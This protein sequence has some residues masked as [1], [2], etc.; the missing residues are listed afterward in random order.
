MVKNKKISFLVVVLLLLMASITIVS[1]ND[2]NTQNQYENYISNV[3][4]NQ[5]E[6]GNS[7]EYQ[8][9]NHK[10]DTLT[11]NSKNESKAGSNSISSNQMTLN[12]SVEN[13]TVTLVYDT[14]KEVAITKNISTV[15]GKPDVTKLGSDYAYA[16]ENGVYTILG[17]EIRRVMKLDSYCQQIY[18]FVPK[19]TFFRKEGSNVKY[20]IS[21][22]KWNVIARSLNAYHVKKGYESVPTPYSI[23]VNL[24]DQKYFYSVYYDA[25]EWIN[26]QQYTCGPTAMS[27]ISQALNCF[28]SERK[29]VG[30]YSTTVA[31]GTSESKIIKYSPLVHMK[32]TDIKDDK[33]SVKNALLNGKMIFWHIS[34][35]Y[36]CI[37]GYN[38]DKDKFLCLNPSGPSHNINAVQWATWSQITNTDRSLKEHG[39]MQ[40]QPN[41]NLTTLDKTHVKYYYYNMGGKYAI[42]NNLEYPNNNILKYSV[43]ASSSNVITIT[44]QTILHIKTEV[45][46]NSRPAD[47][48]KVEIYLNN[49][50]IGTKTISKGVVNLNY[51]LPAYISDKIEVKAKYISLLNFT[52][53]KDVKTIFNKFSAGKTFINSTNLG[54]LENI[55]ILDIIGKKDDVI[56]FKAIVQDYSGRPVNDGK[57]VFKINGNTIKKDGTSYKIKVTSGIAT[58]NYLVPA[59]SAKNYRLTAVFGNDTTRLEDNATMTLQ[60]LSTK[61]NLLKGDNKGNTLELKARIIDENERYVVRDT[62]ISIK[63]N[64]KT[65]I[66]KEK[67]QNGVISYLFDVSSYKK[68]LNITIIAG[69]N[70]LYKS[71]SLIFTLNSQGTLERRNLKITNFKSIPSN[72]NLRFLAKVVDT[73][74]KEIN[75]DL[76]ASLKVNGKTLLN[77]VLIQNGNVDWNVDLSAYQS[78]THNLTL[79]IGESTFYKSTY[80]NTTFVKS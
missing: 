60:R 14:G 74:G 50:I 75:N 34:G 24:A 10:S 71:S 77:K 76:K 44:N 1:A 13:K 20:V 5:Q 18:G 37:I 70:G 58:Y 25:Q 47:G 62:K 65:I 6:I 27:M 45:E 63:I 22:E 9:T 39:F 61:I 35:H 33:T 17:S 23:T 32:L 68:G 8:E 48:G 15:N 64:G 30:T 59:Y 36:M 49:I 28:S 67:V 26:G 42:P 29:L 80:L 55:K 73:D 56:L 51:T 52:S 4:Y 21:R 41:W 69:E 40:V 38:S 53:T 78:G 66:N 43:V 46:L 2:N 54:N 3:D 31:D 57:V 79:I 19:Y 72:N 12:T 7:N 11:K 16:D